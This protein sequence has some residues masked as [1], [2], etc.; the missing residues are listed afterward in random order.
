MIRVCLMVFCTSSRPVWWYL[1][2]VQLVRLCLAFFSV[3]ML[4]V[5]TQEIFWTSHVLAYRCWCVMIWLADHS[6]SPAKRR[7]SRSPSAPELSECRRYSSNSK[8]FFLPFQAYFIICPCRSPCLI[9]FFRFVACRDFSRPIGNF[10]QSN[11]KLQ[12][13]SCWD[14]ALKS[15]N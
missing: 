4:H 2:P 5:V 9:V 1:N 12:V 6:R 11:W 13:T 15:G 7:R 10:Q 8:S 14:L 3:V